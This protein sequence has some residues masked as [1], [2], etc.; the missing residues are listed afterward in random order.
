M[1]V[2]GDLIGSRGEERP[3][4]MTEEVM[5]KEGSTLRPLEEPYDLIQD[6]EVSA[7]CL[8]ARKQIGPNHM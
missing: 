7:W 6:W 5:G 1:L 8:H 4:V 3:L 2:K